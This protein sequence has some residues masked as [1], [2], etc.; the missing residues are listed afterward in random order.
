LPELGSS[1]LESGVIE[2]HT[3]IVHFDSRT[4]VIA[5]TPQLIAASRELPEADSPA[6]GPPRLSHP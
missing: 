1:D 3:D 4:R 5:P 6:V 2:G